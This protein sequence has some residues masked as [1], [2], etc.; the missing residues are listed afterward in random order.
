MRSA[1]VSIVAP[2]TQ[3]TLSNG[4]IGIG[5]Y[6]AG[7]NYYRVAKLEPWYHASAPQCMATTIKEFQCIFSASYQDA[8]GKSVYLCKTHADIYDG[9]VKK[10][11][12][13]TV[14]LRQL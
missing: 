3:A 10:I 7:S 8:T 14:L 2:N 9:P 13:G 1:T 11:R 6:V 4:R 12:P 5:E